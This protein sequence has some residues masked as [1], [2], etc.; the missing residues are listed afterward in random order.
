MTNIIDNQEK[1]EIRQSRVWQGRAMTGEWDGAGKWD[2]EDKTWTGS[3][4][5]NGGMLFGTWKVKGKWE[6]TGEGIGDWKGDGE[7]NC[8]MEFMK[9]IQNY[10]II[11]IFILCILIFALSYFLGNHGWIAVIVTALLMVGL[12]VLAVWITRSTTK[13]KLWLSGTWKDVG[14]F[15]ILNIN[16]TWRLG[17]HTGT[18]S[19]KIKDPKPS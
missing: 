15:R 14:D 9:H 10:V 16:G 11:T 17:Y 18:L 3:G 4:P 5:W 8:N 2:L 1:D 12:I 13:G 19:G 7:L 6:S